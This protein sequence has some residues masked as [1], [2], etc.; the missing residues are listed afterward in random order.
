[1]LATP[2]TYI[3][4]A[5]VYK[6][7]IDTST[8]IDAIDDGLYFVSSSPSSQPECNPG[9]LIKMQAA[10]RG[11]MINFVGVG[12]TGTIRYPTI[13]IRA[14]YIGAWQNGWAVYNAAS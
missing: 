14:K 3:L 4:G 13:K 8:N 2:R 5:I 6:G 1:M 12:A 7:N 11:V 9:L 10:N